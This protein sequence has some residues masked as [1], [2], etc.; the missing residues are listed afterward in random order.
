VKNKYFRV[1][2]LFLVKS[3]S[4]FAIIAFAIALLDYLE[5]TSE[6]L[7]VFMDTY[8]KRYGIWGMIGFML[9]SSL[10][11][12]FFVPRQ[13]LSFVGG[14]AYGIWLGT[15][16]VTFGVT[17]GC[18]LTFVYSRCMAQKVVQK[19][20]GTRIAWL[21]HLFSKNTFG[22]ALSIRVLP[23]G[24]NVLLNMIAGV[25]KIPLVPFCLG[26]ALGYIPQNFV[27]ALLGTG[28]RADP[29]LRMSIAG[30]LYVFGIMVGLWLFRRYRP[31]EKAD[32]KSIIRGILKP[33][34]IDY[35]SPK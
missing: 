28:M 34:S 21:E 18:F 9:L 24:S 11:S 26:S 2:V 30:V 33:H 16:I 29:L 1:Y 22:M 23:V 27:S 7:T 19:K 25:T 10:L 6:T 5:P 12:S 31:D 4:F 17:L 15:F 20:L 3:I 13:V 35:D 8:V 14:Y 32:I